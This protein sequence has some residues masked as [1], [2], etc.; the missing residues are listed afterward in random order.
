MLSLLY[1]TSVCEWQTGIVGVLTTVL[2]APMQLKANPIWK[3][4]LNLGDIA[5][6]NLQALQ[7]LEPLNKRQKC[8]SVS[9]I[10]H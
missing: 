8:Y 7:A 10:W 4:G 6:L 9:V 2:E 3:L 5:T 1:Y